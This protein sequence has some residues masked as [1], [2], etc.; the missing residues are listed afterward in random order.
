MERKRGK[1]EKPEAVPRGGLDRFIAC[2]AKPRVF[3]AAEHRR[4]ASEN[5]NV[6][7]FVANAPNSEYSASRIH[8]DLG[9]SDVNRTL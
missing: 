3:S 9:F 2:G 4:F 7:R 6:D 5:E 1:K 8:R